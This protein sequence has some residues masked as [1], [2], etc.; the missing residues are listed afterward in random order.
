MWQYFPNIEEV[1]IN[2]LSTTVAEMILE[3]FINMDGNIAAKELFRDIAKIPGTVALMYSDANYGSTDFKYNIADVASQITKTV[4][5]SALVGTSYFY[6]G[7]EM[8]KLVAPWANILCDMPAR[9]M[10]EVGRMQQKENNI[11]PFF[12]YYVNH[13]DTQI[14][15]GAVSSSLAKKGVASIAGVVIEKYI[16]MYE[17]AR[18]SALKIDEI[19]VGE[20]VGN[21]K[22]T[23]WDI[24]NTIAKKIDQEILPVKIAILSIATLGEF[25]FREM[26][27]VFNAYSI[28]FIARAAQEEGAAFA[29]NLFT[30]QDINPINNVELAGDEL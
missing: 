9:T 18:K 24:V 12:E 5:K 11:S 4:C 14:T 30:H 8:A 15:I 28:T 23:Y 3:P 1:T 25:C 6:A 21:Y 20:P 16:P 22:D 2:T 26:S 17:I 19:L 13:I 10:I 27:N 29:E 7:K